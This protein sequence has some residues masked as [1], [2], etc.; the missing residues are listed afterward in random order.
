MKVVLTIVHAFVCSGIDYCNSLLSGLPKTWLA[1]L[2][3]ILNAAARLIARLP[4]YSH[5]S[6]YL[7]KD[8]HWLPILARLRYKALFLFANSQQGL[9]PKYL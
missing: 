4:P 9:A 6:D 5:I 3:T 7:I 2:Q 8:L 1:P